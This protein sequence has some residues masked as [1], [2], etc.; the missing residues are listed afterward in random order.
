MPP[1]P[2][3]VNFDVSICTVLQVLVVKYI[4]KMAF[5]CIWLC[6][7][8]QYCVF[9]LIPA[10]FQNVPA[11]KVGQLSTGSGSSVKGNLVK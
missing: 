5:F 7:L 10:T 3:L 11:Q 4:P 8:R 1:A 9:Q 6:M 2:R